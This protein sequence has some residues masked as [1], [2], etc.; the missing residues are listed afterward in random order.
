VRKKKQN[1]HTTEMLIDVLTRRSSNK[2]A[3]T[4][5]VRACRREMGYNNAWIMRHPTIAQ[6]YIT[7]LCYL[8]NKNI[9][10]SASLRRRCVG[11]E[12]QYITGIIKHLAS[13]SIIRDTFIYICLPSLFVDC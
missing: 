5:R 7:Q 12:N 6:P 11:L 8:P 1:V 9:W 10:R 3:Q 4:L 13:R 2:R